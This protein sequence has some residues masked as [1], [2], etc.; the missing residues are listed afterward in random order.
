VRTEHAENPYAIAAGAGSVDRPC[1][2]LLNMSLV[3]PVA[4]PG[5]LPNSASDPKRTSPVRHDSGARCPRHRPKRYTML[6]DGRRFS[7]VTWSSV[8]EHRLGQQIAVTTRG[9]SISWEIG[10]K[11]GSST[12]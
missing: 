1:R 4:D 5:R 2:S 9:G 6:D 11:V 12:N 3:L 8:S 10:R 7:L